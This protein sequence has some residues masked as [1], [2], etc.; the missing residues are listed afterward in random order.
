MSNEKAILYDATKCIAC[1]GCQVA[2]KQWNQNPGEETEF[3]G[4]YENPPELSSYTWMRIL[5]NEKF[6]DGEMHWFFTKHQCMHCTDAACV[7]VCPPKATRH[8]DYKLSDGSTITAVETDPNRCIGCNY[9][10][11]ACPFTVPGY[12]QEKKGMFRCTLCTDRISNDVDMMPACVKACATGA[13][14]FGDR[15]EMIEAAEKRV[16]ELKN[17][18]Y[19]SARLYGKDEMGGLRYLYVLAEEP[20]AYDLPND[21]S[22]PIGVQIRKVFTSPYGGIALGGVAV[23]L[24]VNGIINARNRGMEREFEESHPKV[25]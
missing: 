6:E 9:C 1:R 8:V 23:A 2:C 19:D 4:S 11:V 22:I 18:G 25:G 20:E 7:E 15:D 5:F 16:A 21:P 13:L 10:R 24:I 3:T 17:A 14:L 12:N